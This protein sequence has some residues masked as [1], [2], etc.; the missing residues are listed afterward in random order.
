MVYGVDR[1]ARHDDEKYEYPW[2]LIPY[3]DAVTSITTSPGASAQIPR[4]LWGNNV[5][6]YAAAAQLKFHAE[7]LDEYRWRIEPLERYENRAP[8]L[9]QLIEV[10]A[11]GAPARWK[12][13]QLLPASQVARSTPPDLIAQKHRELV[14]GAAENDIMTMLNWLHISL[15][16]ASDEE[17]VD[18]ARGGFE[19]LRDLKTTDGTLAFPEL[20]AYFIQFDQ[21][22]TWRAGFPRIMLRV[23]EEPATLT[24]RPPQTAG[25]L[26]FGSGTA[27][28]EDLALT[29]DAY[30]APLFLCHSPWIWAIVGQRPQGV[31]V[32]SL[33]RPWRGRAP[34]AAELLHQFMPAGPAKF[35]PCPPFTAAQITE[36]L[37]WW[38]DHLNNLL[39]VVTDPSTYAGS[40]RQYKPRRQFEAQLTF[41]QAGR[42]IQAVLAHQ[43]DHA[44]RRFIAFGALDTLEG[45]GL[46]F[47][48]AVRLTRAQKTLDELDAALPADVAAVLL[49]SARRAVDALRECEQGFMPSGWVSGGNV[50][51]P[52]RNGQ[53]RVMT[54]EEAAAQYLR[55]L[56]NAGHGYAGQ[57]DKDPAARRSPAHVAH[58]RH[59]RRLRPPALPVLA[60]DRL[61][62][63]GPAAKA[64]VSR[65]GSVVQ[66]SLHSV[67]ML[68]VDPRQRPHLSEIIRNLTDR[69]EEA[70]INGW[71]GEVE[72]LNVSL[73][74]AKEKLRS[75]IRSERAKTQLGKQPTPLGMPVLG[76]PTGAT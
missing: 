68:R 41:E 3:P 62:A 28:L 9:V 30:L 2:C 64:R 66:R 8:R 55:I 60:G 71:L 36:T 74:A 61:Q 13:L 54:L 5:L 20:A 65:F 63:G 59:P 27:L 42:R 47:S 4:W 51:V 21:A 52:H 16:L 7:N 75:L 33:G 48:E 12:A 22:L 10:A 29:R 70:Q 57:N 50:T 35:E 31:M 43:R 56:R 73:T 24:T 49:P 40:T 19:I 46:G 32:Y 17:F 45:L 26:V 39:S 38:T 1:S 53:P 15:T 58:R 14:K 18:A 72:G 11:P 69:I 76:H 34:D 67:P 44:S 37:R 25:Q 23:E 6:G